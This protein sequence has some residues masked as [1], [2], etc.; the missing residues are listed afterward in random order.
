MVQ[1]TRPVLVRGRMQTFD[2]GNANKM[3]TLDL[4]FSST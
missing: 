3:S 1:P 4:F 2:N